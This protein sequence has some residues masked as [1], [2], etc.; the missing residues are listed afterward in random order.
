MVGFCFLKEEFFFFHVFS[1]RF[2]FPFVLIPEK[3]FCKASFLYRSNVT[4]PFS[5]RGFRSVSLPYPLFSSSFF[6]LLH[7]G[8]SNFL[9]C[10]HLRIVAQTWWSNST[11][12]LTF[13]LLLF[14]CYL[15]PFPL[16]L[17]SMM[18]LYFYSLSF[19]FPRPPC[20]FV[21]FLRTEIHVQ[22]LDKK[23]AIIW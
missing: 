19:F 6:S 8:N 20:H 3:L 4:D 11:F 9:L 22:Y 10:K 2:T 13:F 12:K 5:D 14:I 15:S 21:Y 18:Y 1:F 7:I 16:F 17:K 23:R